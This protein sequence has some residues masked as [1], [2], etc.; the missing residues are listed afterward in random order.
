MR[1]YIR[2]FDKNFKRKDL[3]REVI[4]LILKWKYK[5]DIIMSTS[6]TYFLTNYQQSFHG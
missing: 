5:N 6:Y 1:R 3:E 4:N 2:N